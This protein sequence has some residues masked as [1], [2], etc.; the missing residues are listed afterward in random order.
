MATR[1][2]YVH[3][4]TVK[5]SGA[6]WTCEF[7]AIFSKY[8]WFL[9]KRFKGLL[10]LIQLYKQISLEKIFIFTIYQNYY[11]GFNSLLSI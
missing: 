9:T 5:F 6:S 11:I 10:E 2:S 8:G 7:Y 1:G 4:S 3:N